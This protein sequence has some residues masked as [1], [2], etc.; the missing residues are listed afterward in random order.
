[1]AR[2]KISPQFR[3]RLSEKLMELGN[4]VIVL[5]V[6][7]QMVSGKEFSLPVFLVGVFITIFCYTI[8]YVI[9]G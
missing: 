7:G 6:F 3:A 2:R 9:G 4:L 8:A 1:M 5:L